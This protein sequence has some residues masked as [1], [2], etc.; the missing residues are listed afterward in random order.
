VLA[1]IDWRLVFF[2]SVPLGLFGTIWAYRVLVEQGERHPAPIDWAGNLSFAV[3]LVLVMIGITYGIQPYRGQDMGWA[4]PVVLA[5]LIGG[6]AILAGFLVIESKVAEPM[7][8]LAL[9][10]I[11][12][13]TA[14]TLSTFLAAC[15]RGGLMFVLIIWLQGIWLP[16]HGYSFENTPLWA[17]IYMLP[18]TAGILVA[19]PLSGILSDHIGSRSLTTGGMIGT[20]VSFV[21]LWLLPVNFGY[22]GF[23]LV[24]FLAGLST[25]AF[26]SPNRAAVMNSLPGGDRGAGAGMNATFQNSAQVLSIGIFFSLMIAGLASKLPV[27]MAAG[28]Q[29][30][31]VD[32]SQAQRIAHLPPVSI[33]F[34]AFLGYNP[35][36]TLLGPKVLGSLSAANAN[37]LTGRSFF[38]HLISAPFR[39]GLHEA[40]AFSI[41][42][43]AVAAVASWSLGK[44]YVHDD[45]QA[46]VADATITAPLP[47]TPAQPATTARMT[48]R[49]RWP[50][51]SRRPVAT[52][53]PAKSRRRTG[54][55]RPADPPEERSQR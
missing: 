29:A 46:A 43:C 4:N 12:A 30:H 45:T 7:F 19:G 24:L 44:R 50:A 17:G 35:I 22:A 39:T 28:L 49:S 16:Q 36:K 51:H 14:G 26:A 53:T 21:L 34:A 31:G 8:R 1:P 42:A 54:S 2:V 20:G 5:E 32:P 6:V 37:A 48:V 40:F 10:R 27:A 13:F 23:A 3:G 33:L 9:F 18:L 11:R 55:P 52:S 25:G 38:P 47:H 41:V 15:A